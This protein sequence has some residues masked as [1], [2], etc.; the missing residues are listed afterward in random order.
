M[1]KTT[2]LS[3]LPGL[4][5]DTSL[6]LSSFY[7]LNSI[8]RRPLWVVEF[9]NY[10]YSYII[11][12]SADWCD[13]CMQVSP[14]IIHKHLLARP[15]ITTNIDQYNVYVCTVR[16][17]CMYVCD[18]TMYVCICAHVYMFMY[19]P[20]RKCMH[21]CVQRCMYACMMTHINKRSKSLVLLILHSFIPDIS[22]APLQVYYYSEALPSKA[23]IFV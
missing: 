6:I 10:S 13:G 5:T 11:S 20:I 1:T 2:N 4:C 17:A 22:I 23:L 12:T 16:M 9:R 18:L 19:I 3:P 21:A 8:N 15:I 14:C 7:Y